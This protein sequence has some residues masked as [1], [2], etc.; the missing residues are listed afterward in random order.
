MCGPLTPDWSRKSAWVRPTSMILMATSFPPRAAVL[1]TTPLHLIIRG[2]AMVFMRR[3]T[4]LLRSAETTLRR[5][6]PAQII[7]WSSGCCRPSRTWLNLSNTPSWRS[8][9]LL[10]RGTMTFRTVAWLRRGIWR[11]HRSKVPG[12]IRCK[13][14]CPIN[15]APP[16]TIWYSNLTLT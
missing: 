16:R 8:P 2:A 12:R 14:G 10:T 11:P 7:I 4:R 3:T 5:N 9:T 1:R 6:Y 15:T 13:A